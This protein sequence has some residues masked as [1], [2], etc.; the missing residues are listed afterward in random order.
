MSDS[1]RT[2][3]RSALAAAVGVVILYIGSVLPTARLT[4]LCAATL[5]VV[6][7]RL[8]CS[9]R[10]ALGCFAVT[11]FASLLLLPGKALAILYTVFLGYYPVIK[12]WAERLH[13]GVYRWTVKLISFNTAALVL[14]VAARAVVSE[15]AGVLVWPLWAVWLGAH[16]A[17]VAYDYALGALILYYLRNLARRI[18]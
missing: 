1:V 10:W 4:V 17:F 13:K 12:L 8:S 5:G 2:L 3:T 15:L 16:A 6:F 7:I 14:Y 18:G 11:A 9:T